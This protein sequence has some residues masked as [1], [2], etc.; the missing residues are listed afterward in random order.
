MT[1]QPESGADSGAEGEAAPDW[2]DGLPSD[3]RP[4]AERMNTPH[5]AVKVAADLRHKLSR[6]IVP[7]DDS[8]SE[9][10]RN[11]CERRRG[12]PATPDGYDYTRPETLPDHLV[13][14][15]PATA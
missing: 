4:M 9:A 8:A 14:Q 15:T 5:D 13:P 3:L 11:A 7:P 1:D 12:P 6:A 2:R 10:E